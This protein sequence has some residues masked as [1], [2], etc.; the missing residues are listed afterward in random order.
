MMKKF[1]SLAAIAAV[2]AS[3]T[4]TACGPSSAEDYIAKAKELENE[5]N[6]AVKAGD[7]A[8]AKELQEEGQK[9]AEEVQKKC[10]EDPEFAAAFAKAAAGEVAE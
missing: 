8:K 2:V 10:A 6:E 1:F 4:L 3:M 5:Y 7:E 9:L